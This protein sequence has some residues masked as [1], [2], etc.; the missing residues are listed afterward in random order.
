[1]G[2]NRLCRKWGGRKNGRLVSEEGLEHVSPCG[3]VNRGVK[4]FE[5]GNQEQTSSTGGRARIVEALVECSPE[6][7]SR[8]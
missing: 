4:R 3:I 2:E 5:Q 6:A 1:M 7:A 8:I